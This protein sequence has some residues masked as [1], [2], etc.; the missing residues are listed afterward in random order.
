[1]N[2]N[3]VGFSGPNRQNILGARIVDTEIT[4]SEHKTYI[5]ALESFKQFK[6]EILNLSTENFHRNKSVSQIKIISS[7]GIRYIKPAIVQELL[8]DQGDLKTQYPHS[9][10]R[11]TATHDFHFKQSPA[12]PL[13]EYAVYNLFSRLTGNL[14]P[15]NELVRFEVDGGEKIYPVLISKTM[16]GV[17][18][19][20]GWEKLNLENEFSWAKWTWLLL[21]SILVK[22]GDGSSTKYILDSEN[23]IH[24][25][26]NEISFVKLISNKQIH[27]AST[28]FCLFKDK[29]LDRNVLMAFC[30]LDS[31]AILS[32]WLDDII[33]KEQEYS[34]LFSFKE[35]KIFF[36]DASNRT[37]ITILF[38]EGTIA[39]LK[40][41]FVS[42][43]RQIET[44]L[45]EN[46]EITPITLLSLLVDL[47]HSQGQVNLIAQVYAKANQPTLESRINWITSRNNEKSLTPSMADYYTFGKSLTFEEIE[48]LRSFSPEK[49]KAELVIS[50]FQTSAKIHSQSKEEIFGA[51]FR[52]L[53]VDNIPDLRRQKLVLKSLINILS[54]KAKKPLSISFQYCHLLDTKSL[55]LFLHENLI[56]LD[57]SYCPNI[58]CDDLVM[59]HRNCPNLQMLNLNGCRGL[60]AIQET[61]WRS[62]PLLFSELRELSIKECANLKTVRLIAPRL[63]QI[64]RDDQI[65]IPV[66]EILTVSLF[67]EDPMVIPNP[68]IET[69]RI[70]DPIPLEKLLS[71]KQAALEAIQRNPEELKNVS[72]ELTDDPEIVLAAVKQKGELLS[73]ASSRLKN[74]KEVVRAAMQEYVTALVFASIELKDDE[75]FILEA[76][77]LNGLALMYV[78]LKIKNNPTVVL[79][80]VRQNGLAFNLASNELKKNRNFVLQVVSICGR[81]LA[82]VSEELKK[83]KEVVLTA[84]EEDRSAIQYAHSTIQM[85]LEGE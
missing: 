27:F 31:D 51:S 72:D 81:S 79:E 56:C 66:F 39:T 63:S 16:N 44:K 62:K 9:A 18:L 6:A 35:K 15:P 41:Q 47:K 83:D 65:E 12:H 58:N 69:K 4:T 14:S 19:K 38:S 84:I 78:T 43:Q 52:D 54:Q 59:I 61:G 85:E 7:C 13:M 71:E 23:F 3:N 1:M 30:N 42:L 40:L 8:D 68:I 36:D 26:G 60:T 11:V 82:Y 67:C 33:K 55:I 32:E 75:E 80:A 25:I 74:N 49:G 57:L 29:G 37:I 28:L 22:P 20:E 17:T 21:A 2:D 45:R 48:P 73:Y 5:T 64:E 50:A 46:N 76:V 70:R 53:C 10:H 34:K 24:S 77:K